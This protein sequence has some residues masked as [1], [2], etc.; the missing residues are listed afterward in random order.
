MN[1]DILFLKSLVLTIVIETI[2]LFIFFRWI[3]KLKDIGI[4]Q[5][6]MTGFLASF[7]TLPYLWFV[8]PTYIDSKLLYIILCESFAI[9]V[10]TFII[11]ALLRIKYIQ[12]LW[13]S[14]SCNIISFFTGLII[15]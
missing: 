3:V 5:L 6:L 2:V 4:A 1:Y 9:L 7:A 8:F 13:C 10:E 12:S 11:A 14:L 15:I